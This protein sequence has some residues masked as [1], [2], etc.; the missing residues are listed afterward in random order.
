MPPVTRFHEEYHT[1]DKVKVTWGPGPW[2]DEPDKAVW[3]D[4]ATGLDCM[5]VRN[6]WGA[7][8][9][10]VGVGPDHPYHGLDYQTCP[11][12]VHGGLTF[13]TTC[14]ETEDPSHF[15]CHIPQPG[16][17]HNVWWFGF[18]CSHAFD[19]SPRQEADN[20][21]RYEKAKAIGDTEGMRIWGRYDPDKVY[22]TLHYV[23]REIEQ[24]AQQ[25]A[26]AA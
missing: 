1:E 8:C 16:R 10:Y 4:E 21:E 11:A 3:V 23:I 13:A 15:I 19:L 25:L 12:E 14:S 26:L 22:R 17:P 20:H 18:D 9:G 6:H 5:I 7:L 24:L 2:Q